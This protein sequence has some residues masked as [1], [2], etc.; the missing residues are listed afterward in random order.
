MK[1]RVVKIAVCVMLAL[2]SIASFIPLGSTIQAASTTSTITLTPSVQATFPYTLT[3]NIQAQSNAVINQLRLHY[4]VEKQN[5]AEVIS[6]SWP[7]F[8]PGKTVD[9]QWVWDMRKSAL[10]VGT[11]LTYWWTASDSSGNTAESDRIPLEFNDTQ[12]VWKSIVEGPVT[13][14]WYN[15]NNNFADSLMAGRPERSAENRKRGGC[16][17]GRYRPYFY[18][19]FPERPVKFAAFS[20]RLAGWG[21]LYRVMTLSPSV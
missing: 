11:G 3:F 14:Y 19:R 1:I 9:T 8:T 18:L 21:Y 15:G 17:S 6:E 13:L 2:L 10:P 4:I 12:H 7:V 5:F 16:R 20:A